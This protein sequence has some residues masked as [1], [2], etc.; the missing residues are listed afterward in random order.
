MD[1]CLFGAIRLEKP[2]LKKKKNIFH[3][4]SQAPGPGPGLVPPGPGPGPAKKD[5]KFKS[6][7]RKP[8]K[9]SCKNEGI[10]AFLGQNH[11]NRGFN[12]LDV[13][14]F[15]VFAPQAN[16]AFSPSKF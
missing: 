15:E 12:F 1:F 3:P 10:I 6:T 7:A 14:N 9:K 5:G 11:Q 4:S 8:A 13:R 16:T 2:V